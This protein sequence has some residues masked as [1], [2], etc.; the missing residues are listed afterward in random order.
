VTA[1][2]GVGQTAIVTGAASGIGRATANKFASKGINVAL[3]DINKQGAEKAAIE[4][5]AK[6]AVSARAFVADLADRNSCREVHQQICDWGEPKFL[7]NNAGVLKL[8]AALETSDD[9]FDTVMNTNFRSGFTLSIAFAKDLISRDSTGS[10]V[11]VSSIHAVISEPNASVYTAAKGAIEASSRTF[12]SEWAEHG[13]RVNCV[14]PGATYTELTTPIYT[15]GI[16]RALF[17]RVPARRIA[18]ASEIAEAIYFFA[19]DSSS[20]CTGTTLDVD[21]GYI[22]DGSLPGTIY[23]E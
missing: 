21:G 16:K 13:I 11:N 7:V 14:R 4:I 2:K 23:A 1:L 8:S 17:E 12:A 5:A 18:E 15:E 10:I 20:Y 9:L 19:S 6:F 3:V 22:M